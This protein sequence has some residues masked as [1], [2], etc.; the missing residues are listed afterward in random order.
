MS[1][2]HR[3]R[4]SPETDINILLL[5]ET[6][7]G[8]TTFVNAF[9]NCLFYNALDDALEGELKVLIPASFVVT[10]S[11]DNDSKMIHVGSPNKNENSKGDGESSTQLCRSYL[12]PMGNR[13]IRLIDGPGVGD[14]RGVDHEARNFEHILNYI[15]NYEHLNGIC[16]LFKPQ[17]TRLHVYF[18]YCVKELLRHLHV[19]AKDNIMF[20]FTNS[21][22]TF[23]R[24]GET[25]PLLKKLLQEIY[26]KTG[27]QVPFNT[28]NTF[29]FDNESFRFLAVYKQGFK[30]LIKDKNDY[31]KSWNKSVE[32]FSRLIIRILECNFH[33][34]QDMRSLNEAQLL[35]HKLS[36]PIAEIVTLIQENISLAQQYKEK[37]LN[38]QVDRSSNKIPQKT[39]TFVPLRERLTVCVNEKCTE[40]INVNGQQTIN[41]K[42]NCHVGCSLH[43][44]VQECIG[45]PIIKRC[46]ALRQT[47]S[48]IYLC[49][50]SLFS[51]QILIK[52]VSQNSKTSIFFYYL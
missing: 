39:G 32:E 28:E 42:S 13:L 37:L 41:Y 5:G 36:R 34:V 52:T 50:K 20:V 23:Y 8:K 35:V 17:V 19:N 9:V 24:P 14:T 16:I 33:A 30:F 31:S 43:R 47:G 6:G 38:N 18:R 10:E 2:H 51:F 40:I 26:E 46:R 27:Q 29:M 49:S 22:S 1:F 48:F 7:V 11:Q 3:N 12:F 4:G 21:R 15:S 25:T 44:I 45:H